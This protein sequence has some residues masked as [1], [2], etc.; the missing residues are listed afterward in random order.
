MDSK[1][2]TDNDFRTN[3]YDWYDSN[4]KKFVGN[5]DT[6]NIISDY[7][8]YRKRY[9]HLLKSYNKDSKIIELGC[10]SGYF[11][12]FLKQEG[13]NNIYGIDI[14][15]QQI[16]KAKLKGLN[17][18][19]KN[20]FEFFKEDRKYDIVFA[21]DFIEHFEKNELP[22]L[23]EGINKIMNKNGIIIIRTPNGQGIAPQKYIYG[24]LTHLTIFNPNS[25][26]QILKLM[27]FDEINFYET[28]PVSVNLTGFIRAV[29]W[30]LIKVVFNSIRI[31]ESGDWDKILTQNLICTARKKY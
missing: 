26:F 25:L 5:E 27:G 11:L 7:R 9:L 15:E 6:S 16:K 23:F 12:Q 30:K 14:S 8:T 18:E 2:F 10:G 22:D 28:C 13:F 3:F 20:V 4:F 19:V 21:L 17:V 29:L 1:N 24:D 31:I